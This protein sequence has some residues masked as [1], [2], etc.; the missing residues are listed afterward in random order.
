MTKLKKISCARSRL[1]AI[2]PYLPINLVGYVYTIVKK[3]VVTTK[4]II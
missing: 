3:A 2:H 1:N 4:T